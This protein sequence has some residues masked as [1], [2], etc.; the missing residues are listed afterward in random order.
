MTMRNLPP[1]RMAAGIAL[2]LLLSASGAVQG[3][4]PAPGKSL[5][6]KPATAP[7]QPSADQLLSQMPTA[8][9]GR[10]DELLIKSQPR[11]DDRFDLPPH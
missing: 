6:V 8:K 9:P 3:L 7:A 5:P 4:T 10:S 11:P 2:L 1:E